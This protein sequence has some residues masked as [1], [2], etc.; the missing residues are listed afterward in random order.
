MPKDG[1]IVDAYC[2]HCGRVTTQVF[3]VKFWFLPGKWKCLGHQ[4]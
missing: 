2:Q 4:K 3:E 1:D